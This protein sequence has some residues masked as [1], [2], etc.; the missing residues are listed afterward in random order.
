MGIADY[1]TKR[2]HNR[3]F[4][5]VLSGTY[6]IISKQFDRVHVPDAD[7]F[8]DFI[9]LDL[10]ISKEFGFSHH[11]ANSTQPLSRIG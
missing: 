5:L 3:A 11:R 2:F 9:S 10:H 8:I 7:S 1:F 6:F 4:A